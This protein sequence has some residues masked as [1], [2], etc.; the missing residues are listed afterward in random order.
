MVVDM[1]EFGQHER[2]PEAAPLAG[3]ETENGQTETIR[4]ALCAAQSL[5]TEIPFQ[6]CLSVAAISGNAGHC[7][8]LR[9]PLYRGLSLL[10]LPFKK[11]RHAGNNTGLEDRPGHRLWVQKTASTATDEMCWFMLASNQYHLPVL[12]PK[13]LSSSIGVIRVIKPAALATP[14]ANRHLVILL[15]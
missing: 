1:N 3:W 4:E 8:R 6:V 10:H 15:N 9:P 12:L 13:F 5:K 11:K 2:P 7:R 14:F